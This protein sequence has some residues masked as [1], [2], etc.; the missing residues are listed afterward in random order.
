M[1]FMRSIMLF[2]FALV[3]YQEKGMHNLTFPLLKCMAA[4]GLYFSFHGEQTP[5]IKGLRGSFINFLF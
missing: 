1:F 3:E 2:F 4:H 5:L